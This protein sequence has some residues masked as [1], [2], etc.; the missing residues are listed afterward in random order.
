MSRSSLLLAAATAGLL[1]CTV[2]ELQA[3]IVVPSELIAYWR[4]NGDFPSGGSGHRWLG[5]A[6]RTKAT[7]ISHV[8]SQVTMANIRDGCGY[9][10]RDLFGSAHAGAVN[11]VLCDGPVRSLSYSIDADTYRWLGHR[12]SGRPIDVSKF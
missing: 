5:A 11:F 3:S 4:L 10:S 1:A 9:D 2:G 7:G 6:D 8:L 12:A